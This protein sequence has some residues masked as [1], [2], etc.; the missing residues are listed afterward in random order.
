MPS[1]PTSSLGC[2]S[3]HQLD[4]KQKSVMV[5]LVASEYKASYTIIHDLLHLVVFAWMSL[6]LKVSPICCTG[7]SLTLMTVTFI[8]YAPT[9]MPPFGL[10][11]VKQCDHA[12]WDPAICCCQHLF[13]GFLPPMSMGGRTKSSTLWS[14]FPT[15]LLHCNYTLRSHD[16]T[17]CVCMCV[18]VC[19]CV[20]VCAYVC[21]CVC[22][23]VCV[24][25]CAIG[26]TV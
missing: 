23:Y 17:W 1:T 16:Y 13:Y 14:H 3:S 8:S 5:P 26:E 25:V 10:S 22:A 24:C 19:V 6:L 9:P 7:P 15:V 11:Y 20:C 4:V 2:V 21:V 12:H 18:C